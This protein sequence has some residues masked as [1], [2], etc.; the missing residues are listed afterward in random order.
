MKQFLNTLPPEKT[1]VLPPSETSKRITS[2]DGNEHK[3]IDKFYI[4][5]L[6]KPSF[7]Y[8]LSGDINNKHE[9]FLILRSLHYGQNWW[10]NF[11]RDKGIK[12]VI[13]NKEL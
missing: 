8:G 11:I 12:Y 10:I 6:N 4:Y 13:I 7:Y 3:F 5:Y 2:I 1:I 9:F